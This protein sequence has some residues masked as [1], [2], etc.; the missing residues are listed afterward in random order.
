[1][2]KQRLAIGAAVAAGLLTIGSIAGGIVPTSAQTPEATRAATR[3]TSPTADERL[4]KLAANLGVTVDQLKAG[5]QKT[6]LQRIDD[7][8]AAGRLTADQAAA[9]KARIA[10]GQPSGPGGPGAQGG[11]GRSGGALAAAATASG[12]DAK[13]L[14][15]EMRAGRS[16]AQVAAAH[17]KSRDELKAALQQQFSASL[18]AMIDRVPPVRPAGAPGGAPT[19]PRT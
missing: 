12:I 7:A 18:D 14:M 1:M 16:L 19:A 13:T 15:T 9:A 10:S 11:P 6:E 5:M 3:P 2:Q 4:A 17:G 8:V